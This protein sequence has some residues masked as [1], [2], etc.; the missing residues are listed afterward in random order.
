MRALWTAVDVPDSVGWVNCITL[1]WDQ[2]EGRVSRPDL[3]TFLTT[4]AGGKFVV[5]VV[6][7]GLGDRVGIV[8]LL[9]VQAGGLVIG[10]LLMW[11]TLDREPL[12]RTET[13]G[14]EW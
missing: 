8:P 1:L 9:D 7:G 2:G 11:V 12:A 13:V 10:G 4:E 3:G 5:A 14:P 6:A